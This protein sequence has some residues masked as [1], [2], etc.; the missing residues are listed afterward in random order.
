M[1]ENEY[2]NFD[3]LDDLLDEDPTKLDETVAG[4]LQADESV[5]NN[6]GDKEKSATSE[7]SDC[8]QVGNGSE[9]D[10]EL[11]EMMSDLQNEFANLMKQSGNENNIKTGDF[12]KLVSALEEA[13]KIPREGSDLGPTGLKDSNDKG[14][15]NGNSPGFKNIVSNT[16]DRLKENGNKV[17]TSLAEES[18]ESQR[19]GKNNNID[20]VLSQLLDQMVAS[21][22]NK[23]R[24]DQFDPKDGEMDDA[25]MKILDQMTS[26]EVL[27]EPMK[28]MRSEFETWFQEKGE[29]E[30][31]KEKIGVY[32]RQFDLV[33]QI[34][35]TYELKDYDEFKHKDRVTKYLDELEQL[36]DSP[37][38]SANSLLKNGNEEDD[39]MKMLEVD[40]NDPNLGNLDKELA[41]GCKQ[42]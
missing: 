42:Q 3:D 36:G 17:D 39:L 10:P 28:E 5:G 22:G 13:T 9:E 2:D 33:K 8:V 7:N 21:G 29:N 32:K 23:N 37:I 6:V 41:D 38:R 34:V 4:K 16:L 11:K 24:D 40:G 25:I 27:Y 26:K 12:N 14:T 31:H 18:K 30:E 19:S 35:D 20:D 15:L 1:S